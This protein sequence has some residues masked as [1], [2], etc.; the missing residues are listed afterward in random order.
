MRPIHW[1]RYPFLFLVIP[2]IA[3]IL[4]S[5]WMFDI[6]SRFILYS[7]IGSLLLLTGVA[8]TRYGKLFSIFSFLFIFLTGVYCHSCRVTSTRYKDA[9]NGSPHP[10]K[11]LSPQT[12]FASSRDTGILSGF[13]SAIR[14]CLT[15]E[16]IR[17][18]PRAIHMNLI[19][20]RTSVTK[21]FKP[22]RFRFRLRHE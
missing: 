4:A 19:T 6:P 21:T 5:E 15:P 18:Q 1:H 7:I 12:G 2:L 22:K 3:G 16:S 10:I 11:Q 20:T 13:L 14:S 9:V 8:R 17:C